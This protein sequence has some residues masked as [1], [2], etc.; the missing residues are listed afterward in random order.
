MQSTRSILKY[1]T[2][3]TKSLKA[4]FVSLCRILF[5]FSLSLIEGF[6]RKIHIS[7]SEWFF[8][9][10]HRY[11]FISER[12]FTRS[13]GPRK[14]PLWSF[15]E[16]IG[17]LIAGVHFRDTLLFLAQAVLFLPRTRSLHDNLFEG[18]WKKPQCC[19]WENKPFVR[20]FLQSLEENKL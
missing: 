19:V 5:F 12:V 14:L 17:E 4:F 13:T 3:S 16:I 7:Y 11:P 15:P 20:K 10:M 8:S 18:I 1:F 6:T 2:I 9:D